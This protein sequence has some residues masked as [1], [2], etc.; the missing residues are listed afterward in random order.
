MKFTAMA[1]L[2]AAAAFFAADTR[3]SHAEMAASHY[4][5][6]SMAASSQ[7]QNCYIRSRSECPAFQICFDNPWYTGPA[8]TQGDHAQADVAQLRHAHAARRTH[9]E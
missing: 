4:P 3:P 2:C 1:T 7:M 6:C 9:H 8:T 5:F